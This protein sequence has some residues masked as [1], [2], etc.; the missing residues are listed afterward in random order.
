[1]I[2]V[3]K[4]KIDKEVRNNRLLKIVLIVIII[5]TLFISL[6]VLI[7]E[8]K[9]KNYNEGYTI[10]INYSDYEE[11]DLKLGFDPTFDTYYNKLVGLGYGTVNSNIG[12][13]LLE[14]VEMNL[15]MFEKLNSVIKGE[16]I[17]L[18]ERNDKKENFDQ[19]Y[20]NK[21][22]IKNI[23]NQDKYFRLNLKITKSTKNALGAARFMIVTGDEF[24]GL[25]YNV[26][27]ISDGEETEVVAS[28]NVIESDY[29]G[30]LYI[31][32]PNKNNNNLLTKKI[33]D[34]WF[35]EPLLFD[36][37]TGFF[38]YYSMIDNEDDLYVLKPNETMAFTICFWLEASD[39]DHQNEIIGGSVSF[40]VIYETLDYML[41]NINK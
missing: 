40:S 36:A 30:P 24:S 33:E 25:K 18:L 14:N 31:T 4:K 23:G 8:S 9:N 21:Y 28:K 35:C 34:A 38:H 7:S 26:L 13:S 16:N 39:K 19:Y 15:T 20:C 1:M 37:K 41:E 12:G 17:Q 29:I 5:I 6:F 2:E 11:H 32:D 10:M 22:Y 27:S 3:T